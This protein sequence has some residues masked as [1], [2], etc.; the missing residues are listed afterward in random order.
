MKH[1]Y[2]YLSAL[3]LCAFALTFVSCNDDE[4]DKEFAN[5]EKTNTEYY[6]QLF[7]TTQQRI[8]GGDTSW[9]IIRNHT[10]EEPVATAPERNII[11][12]VLN[13]GSGSGYPLFS[14]SVHVHYRGRLLPSKSHPEGLV[15]DETWLGNY[16][17]PTMYPAKLAL[18][19]LIDG[20]ATAL[21]HMHI[22]D[23]WQVYIP[24]QLGYGKEKQDA[25]PA[26]STLMFDITLM[27][28][29]RAGT[30]VPAWKAPRR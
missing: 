18:S 22:G 19:A 9:K 12:H 7:S 25:V 20:F 11:V 29:Y 21:Q 13:E 30:V 26:Y 10:F 15:F 24:Y 16:N 4:E 2:Y 27:G 14:D 3:F 8:A 28:Y 6:Q 1:T 23:R 5:W 17:L